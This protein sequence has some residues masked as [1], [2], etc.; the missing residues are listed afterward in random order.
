MLEN[1]R[2][3]HGHTSGSQLSDRAKSC[4]TLLRVLNT[5]SGITM[6]FYD[7]H[8]SPGRRCIFP[9]KWCSKVG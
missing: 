5:G 4:L 9:V 8:S 3:I 6:R 2:E 7:V 1:V